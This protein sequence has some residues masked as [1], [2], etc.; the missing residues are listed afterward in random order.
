MNA[1]LGEAFSEARDGE[2]NA[3]RFTAAYPL[4]RDLLAALGEIDARHGNRAHL[5]PMSGTSAGGGIFQAP[6]PLDAPVVGL[7][8]EPPAVA[9]VRQAS[10]P[11]LARLDLDEIVIDPDA[12]QVCA[13]AAVTLEQLNRALADELGAT[14]RVPGA[15]LTSYQYAAVGATFMTGGMGPQRRYFSDSVVEISLYDGDDLVAIDGDALSAYAGT[16]GWSG[17][18]AA[19]RCRYYRFPENEIAFALP[20][21]NEPAD[22]ARLLD[23]LA[24]FAWLDLDAAGAAS[25]ARGGHLILGLEHVSRAS[26]EPLVNDGAAGEARRIAQAL[27]QK[28]DAAG[29]DGLIFVNG[30]SR[31]SIDEFIAG[32]LDDP[33]ADDLR[34]AGIALEHAEIFP[35]ADT[36]REVREAIPYAAR[37]QS[38]R[39]RL[40]YKNHTDANIRLA[41]D[42][43]AA[44]M[45]QLWQANRD[46]VDA[47]EQ[48]FAEH[49]DVHGEVLVYGHLNPYGVDPHNR[50]TMS[51]DDENAF[52]ACREFLLRQ[53]ALFF[54][55]L[56]SLCAGGGGELIGG[57][58]AADSERG[59]YQALGGPEQAPQALRQRFERQRACVRAASIRFNWRA[60]EPYR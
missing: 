43:V 8:F 55:A 33:L 44:T 15:D 34:I 14:C 30:L 59:I 45:T 41:R 31:D 36:M 24:P 48:Y 21:S 47:V 53:R 46:Y 60:L 39:G 26:M 52:S 38:P 51:S 10:R 4:R 7:K 37:M 50:V 35:R 56:A 42:A 32:L 12:M 18:V 54:R 16:Y 28:C 19:L 40:V 23:H 20:V 29:A 22:L 25:S 57:E 1:V 5:L 11:E 3:I 58:K 17:I 49:A 13:G 27:Q 2:N 9:R 6:L